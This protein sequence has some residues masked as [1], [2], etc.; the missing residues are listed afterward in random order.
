MGVCDGVKVSDNADRFTGPGTR[1]WTCWVSE[2][3]WLEGNGQEENSNETLAST[4]QATAAEEEISTVTV[5]ETVYRGSSG[6][7]PTGT[8]TG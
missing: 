8:Y 7:A 1:K 6:R 2:K 3:E 4:E 5:Y